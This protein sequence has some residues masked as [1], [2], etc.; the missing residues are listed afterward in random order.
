MKTREAKATKV[1][2]QSKA[3]TASVTDKQAKK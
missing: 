3:M 2:D 1:I